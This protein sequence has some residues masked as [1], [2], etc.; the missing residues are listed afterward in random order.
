MD[1]TKDLYSVFI[2]FLGQ[3]YTLKVDENS[4]GNLKRNSMFERKLFLF[5]IFLVQEYTLMVDTNFRVEI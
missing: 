3:E 1:T 5:I 4:C 2:V